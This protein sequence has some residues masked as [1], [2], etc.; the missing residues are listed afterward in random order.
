MYKY[1]TCKAKGEKLYWYSYDK[2][3]KDLL[4]VV[5]LMIK[6]DKKE[7]SNGEF[8]KA[9]CMFVS[10]QYLD[11]I[12]PYLIK[13]EYKKACE[14]IIYGLNVLSLNSKYKNNI[15]QMENLIFRN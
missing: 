11:I 4:S 10:Q 5:N 9:F 15:H 8:L 2:F 14:D 7:K 1:S 12:V 3:D 6:Y 13:N